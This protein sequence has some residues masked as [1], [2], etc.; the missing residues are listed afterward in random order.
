MCMHVHM[1]THMPNFLFNIPNVTWCLSHLEEA[2]QSS[3]VRVTLRNRLP[4]DARIFKGKAMVR[5]DPF[6]NYSI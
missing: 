2:T 3:L 5:M 6:P 4:S 1:C